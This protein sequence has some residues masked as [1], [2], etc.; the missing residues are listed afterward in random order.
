MPKII[1]DVDVFQT[2]MKVVSERGYSGATTR[3]MA[4][5]AN[6]SE[7]TL[8]RKYGSKLELVKQ[9]ISHIV[10]QSGFDEAISYTGHLEADLLR[11]IEAYRSSAMR[12]GF[13]FSTL[14]ADFTRYPE[15]SKSMKAPLVMFQS[16]GKLIAKYQDEGKLRDEN[17]EHAVAA[18]LGPMI[19]G[20]M[21]NNAF[22]GEHYP[23]LRIEDHLDTFLSG[24]R[25]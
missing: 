4:E 12:Y 9:A 15:L 5:A 13:F 22:G 3:E 10:K 17:P 11:V 16:V 25:P 7:V 19:Y 18:L 2:V 1:E 14:L 8:F 24:R 21:I 23:P 20:N 6:V